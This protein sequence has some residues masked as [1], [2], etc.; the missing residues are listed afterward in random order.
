MVSLVTGPRPMIE[1][2]LGAAIMLWLAIAAVMIMTLP[3]LPVDETRYLTV[4]WEMKRSGQWLLPTL[5]GEPYSH[6]PPLLFWLINLAWGALGPEVWAARFVSLAASASV[7]M[8]TYRLGRQ[9]MPEQPTAPSLAVLLVL[10]GPAVFLYGA[11][12]MFDQLLTVWVLLGVSALCKEAQK[13]S[14]GAWALGAFAIGMG[15]LTKGPVILLYLAAPALLVTYWMAPEAKLSLKRWYGSLAIAVAIGALMVLA[16]AIPAAVI[17]GPEFARMI[18]WKQSAGRMV[19]SF[20]HR[21]PFW[22]YVPV[23]AAFLFPLFFWRPLWRRASKARHLPL[24]RPAKFLLC[25]LIPAFVAFSL[26]SGKQPHYMLPLL[27]GIALFLGSLLEEADHRRGDAIVLCLPFSALFLILA[28]GPLASSWAGFDT[29]TSYIS[30]GLSQFSVGFSLL[31]AAVSMGILLT[32]KKDLR[33]QALAMGLSS[34]LLLGAVTVQCYRYV[35]RFYDL[36]PLAHALK[37]YTAGPLVFVNQYAGEIGYLARLERPIE[38][39]KAG[40]LKRWFAAHPDGT[41]VA[42]TMT[43]DELKRYSVVHSQPYRTQRIFSIFRLTAGPNSPP[44][45]ADSGTAVEEPRQDREDRPN[46][47]P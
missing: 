4:A 36:R 29:E 14:K 20:H 38:V 22:F 43:R 42:R 39:V 41:A 28:F 1:P 8:L 47:G 26:I 37:P 44:A 40:Q 9:L 34:A 45:P 3:P 30:E 11:L 46:G 31:C 15:L 10:A 12:I 27:P 19:E 23:L 21:Q 7:L 13:P 35:Y 25:F 24:P 32:V 6:K 18:F 17:G 16:W 5:N 2:F 33:W